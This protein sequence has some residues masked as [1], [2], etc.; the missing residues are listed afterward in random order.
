M[1]FQAWL[2]SECCPAGARQPN[3]LGTV[4]ALQLHARYAIPRVLRHPGHWQRHVLSIS[5]HLWHWQTAAESC[6]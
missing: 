6:I 3:L 5:A 2:W 1:A 4:W